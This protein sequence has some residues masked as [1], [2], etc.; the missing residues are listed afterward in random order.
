MLDQEE[1]LGCL[2]RWAAW[3]VKCKRFPKWD[4]EEIVSEGW[5]LVHENSAKYDPDRS[6]IYTWL[7]RVLTNRLPAIY[8]KQTKMRIWKAGEGT[9]SIGRASRPT[10]PYVDTISLDKFFDENVEDKGTQLE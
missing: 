10:T 3:A 7:D 9:D 4:Y 8:K 5:I 1:L 6:G 2:D